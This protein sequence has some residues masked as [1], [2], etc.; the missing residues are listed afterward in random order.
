MSYYLRI[1]RVLSRDV[2]IFSWPKSES[3]QGY[4]KSASRHP[5]ESQPWCMSQA[6]WTVGLEIVHILGWA[7]W[8][9]VRC[10]INDLHR[11][12]GR[13]GATTC[14]LGAGTEL[15]RREELTRG[16][17]ATPLPFHPSKGRFLDR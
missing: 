4:R 16:V 12:K 9:G 6:H 15:H 14:P 3:F 17:V 13:K 2:L 10:W 11:G 5:L 1:S 8:R 7:Q